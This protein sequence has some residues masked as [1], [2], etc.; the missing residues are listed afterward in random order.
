MEGQARLMMYIKE[1]SGI[2]AHTHTHIH[3]CVFIFQPHIN[4]DKQFRPQL[5]LNLSSFPL[6]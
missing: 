3:L 4:P 1:V 6:P 5:N 2:S